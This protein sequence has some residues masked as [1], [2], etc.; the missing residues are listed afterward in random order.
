MW[1]RYHTVDVKRKSYMWCLV[2]KKARI[3]IFFYEDVQDGKI[4]HSVRNRNVLVDFID[5]AKLK[6]QNHKNQAL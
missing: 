2:N 5:D 6:S 1:L 4:K 3:V